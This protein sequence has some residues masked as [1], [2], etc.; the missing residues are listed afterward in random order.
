MSISIL[1]VHVH[2]VRERTYSPYGMECVECSAVCEEGDME[3]EE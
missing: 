1:H 2:V 3:C